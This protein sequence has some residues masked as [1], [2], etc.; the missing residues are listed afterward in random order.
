MDFDYNDKLVEAIQKVELTPED[1]KEIELRLEAME[2]QFE[3]E[4]RIKYSDPQG[5]L[6]RQYTI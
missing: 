2:R 4:F 5:F 3:E 1:I 6:N